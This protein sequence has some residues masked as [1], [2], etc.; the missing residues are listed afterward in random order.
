MVIAE[1]VQTSGVI[2]RHF[3]NWFLWKVAAPFLFLLLIWFPY[4]LRGESHPF[5]AAFAHGELLIFAAVL[6]IEVSFEG[7]EIRGAPDGS[8]SGWF[9]AFLPALRLMALMVIFIFGIVRYDVLALTDGSSTPSDQVDVAFKLAAY[10]AMNVATAVLAF[11]VAVFSCFK[12]C[13]YHIGSRFENV[14]Q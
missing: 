3:Y 4:V 11:A 1:S 10:A 9:D 14:T 8:F 5:A 7:E 12:H 6:F 2:Y 13:E